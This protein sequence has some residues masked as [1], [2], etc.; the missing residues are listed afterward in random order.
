MQS[1][2]EGQGGQR[3]EG[4]VRERRDSEDSCGV[5]VSVIAVLQ[6]GAPPVTQASQGRDAL[7]DTCQSCT[8]KGESAGDT[9]AEP[10]RKGKETFPSHHVSKWCQDAL[11]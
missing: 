8:Q 9:R 1:T 10:G 2:E 7:K 3:A 11:W 6:R 5:E 4:P